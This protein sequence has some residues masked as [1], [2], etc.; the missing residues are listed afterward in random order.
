MSV[1]KDAFAN[2]GAGWPRRRHARRLL[3]ELL[4]L[5]EGFL[6]YGGLAGRDL[7][8]IAVGLAEIVETSNHP[9]NRVRHQQHTS[10]QKSLRALG[11]PLAAIRSAATRCVVDVAALP[12]GHPPRRDR[13]DAPRDAAVESVLRRSDRCCARNRTVPEAL[14]DMNL[15]RLATPRRVYTQ[16]TPTTSSR[17]SRRSSGGATA[18]RPAHRSPATAAAQLHARFVRLAD[19][20]LI[21]DKTR[22][23]KRTAWRL[24]DHPRADS[25]VND[26]QSEL[27]GLGMKKNVRAS[28]SRRWRGVHAPAGRPGADDLDSI[29]SRMCR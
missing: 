19:G 10:R 23:A 21:L 17:C 18:A 8:A 4:I 26:E 28:P 22:A 24:S 25:A 20:V 13:D 16:S 1:K 27:Q 3:R 7:D 15:V 9:R 14:A 6:T 5:T 12:A 2:I 11:V 29:T